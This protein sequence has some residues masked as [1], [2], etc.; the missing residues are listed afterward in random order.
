MTNPTLYFI[1]HLLTSLYTN[2]NLNERK[3]KMSEFGPFFTEERLAG[4][5]SRQSAY[6]SKV[7]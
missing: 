2:T 1:N 6:L 4:K 7:W 5:L 3:V